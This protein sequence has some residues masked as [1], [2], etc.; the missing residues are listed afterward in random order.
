MLSNPWFPS[1]HD[2]LVFHLL[3]IHHSHS[4]VKKNGSHVMRETMQVQN[5]Q[6][7]AIYAA[8]SE[9]GHRDHAEKNSQSFNEKGLNKS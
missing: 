4:Q 1:G 8:E 9:G 2:Q 6:S 5:L 7:S 3:N